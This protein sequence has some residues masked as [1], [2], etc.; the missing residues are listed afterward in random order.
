[1]SIVFSAIK[2]ALK[3]DNLPPE[4]EEKLLQMQRYQERQM[5]GP[6]TP[7]PT[8]PTPPSRSS[9]SRKR[10][11]SAA[12]A[13]PAAA[14]AAAATTTAAAPTTGAAEEAVPRDPNWEPA[15]KRNASRSSDKDT[16]YVTGPE[17]MKSFLDYLH[18][19]F[20]H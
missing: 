3:Q 12:V 6:V 11:A 13:A 5:K 7:Q 1:M 19:N 16:K 18:A 4:I 9:H 2:S 15:R 17:L 8:P 20:A 10:T 14:T